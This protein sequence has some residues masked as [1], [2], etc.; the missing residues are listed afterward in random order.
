MEKILKKKLK[1]IFSIEKFSHQGSE[2]ISNFL[3]V[4][5]K[6]RIFFEGIVLHT[7]LR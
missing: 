3:S 4:Y 2:V 5:P 6:I 7:T 1:R